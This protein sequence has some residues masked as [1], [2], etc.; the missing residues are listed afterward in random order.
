M[1]RAE[2]N[3]PKLLHTQSVLLL[4]DY[5]Y[6]YIYPPITRKRRSA[7]RARFGDAGYMPTTLRWG[8]SVKWLILNSFII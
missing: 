3:L 8:K 5:Y 6:W 4:F 2:L 1:Q 7:V